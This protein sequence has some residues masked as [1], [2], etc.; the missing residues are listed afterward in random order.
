MVLH[1]INVFGNSTFVVGTRFTDEND[2]V[3]VKIRRVGR[4]E[5]SYTPGDEVALAELKYEA[6]RSD[7]CFGA[8]P[9]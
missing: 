1:Y 2:E 4:P 5:D 7:A 3:R 6:E 8:F 9:R